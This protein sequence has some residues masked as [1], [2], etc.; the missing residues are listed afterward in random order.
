MYTISRKEFFLSLS[1][2]IGEAPFRVYFWASERS[3]SPILEALPLGNVFVGFPDRHSAKKW[4]ALRKDAYL[5]QEYHILSAKPE[6]I[7]EYLLTQ[8]S[9]GKYQIDGFIWSDFQKDP[10]LFAFSQGVFALQ[11]SLSCTD[12]KTLN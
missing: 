8:N 6:K 11:Q 5:S 7:L 1:R 10:L 2:E 4:S 3:D 9:T 12:K